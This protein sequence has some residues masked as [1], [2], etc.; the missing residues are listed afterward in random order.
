MRILC[1]DVGTG[2]QD[3]LCFDSSRELENSLKLVMPAPTVI[4]ADRIRAATRR[5][6]AVLLTGVTMGGGP[7]AWAAEGHLR[8][9]LTLY[10]TP[11]AAQ[12]FDD[13]LER[14]R[15]M[16]VRL[17]SEDEAAALSG[18]DRIRM[19][20]F[21]MDAII[22]ALEQFGANT[23]F[24]AVAVAVFDHGAAP[25]GQSDRVFRF[26]YLAER[27]R[28]GQGLAAF[29]FP[30]DQVPARLSRLRAVAHTMPTDLPALVMDT[31]PAAVLGAL[32]DPRVA[33]QERCI[34]ANIGNF[35]CLAF[36]MMDGVISG[37]FEH[38]TGEL[39]ADQL[40]GFVRKLMAG[41][42]SNQEVFDSNGHGALMFDTR[43]GPAPNFVAIT[44]PRRGLLRHSSLNPYY[45]VPCGDMMLAGCFGL[46]RAWAEKDER[47]AEA[48]S[49]SLRAA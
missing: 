42:I 46:L 38:H 20:D 27:V 29:A 37:L 48:V 33:S 34:V 9:G 28:A 41:T 39:Q 3:I 13:D 43:G 5:R 16:G 11:D 24:D 49:A 12:T 14:V 32:E 25:P 35:H 8:A 4:V 21:W 19:R 47:I 44:G 45:A 22:G 7:C 17:V 23:Q 18:V 36:R 30:R 40:E 1:V 15:E 31:A 26:E 10:A 2:T 6:E